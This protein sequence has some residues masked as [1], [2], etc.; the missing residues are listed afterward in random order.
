[1]QKSARLALINHVVTVANWNNRS[2]YVSSRFAAMQQTPSHAAMNGVKAVGN[3]EQRALAYRMP[4]PGR[5]N[6]V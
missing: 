1:M 5:V 3:D 4:G 2:M 6:T